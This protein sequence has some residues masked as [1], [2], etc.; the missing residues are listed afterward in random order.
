M[1]LTRGERF[2]DART[3]HN[4]HGNQTMEEVTAATGISRS[5]I[6]ALEDDENA[7]DVGY[8]KVAKL[9]AHYCVTADFLLGLT[10]D[11]HIQKCAVDDLNLTAAAVSFLRFL[12]QNH[13][14]DCFSRLLE[15]EHFRSFVFSLI[16]YFY[17]INAQNV[18]EDISDNMHTPDDRYPASK[19]YIEKLST[20]AEDP[21]WSEAERR[22]IQAFCGFEKSYCTDASMLLDNDVD[23]FHLADIQEMKIKKCLD[24]VMRQLEQFSSNGSQG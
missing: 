13:R 8:A 24:N 14:S 3:V 20:A 17:V 16:D 12:S 1:T 19:S 6:Q 15:L 22:Y 18:A 9:A 4:Q 10:N 5:M 7:R 2:K 23:G 21:K 11:P